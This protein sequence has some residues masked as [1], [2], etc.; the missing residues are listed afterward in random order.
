M[1]GVERRIPGPPP[2]PLCESFKRTAS[3]DDQEDG[4]RETFTLENL[5]D[6]EEEGKIGCCN[7]DR[8][9]AGPPAQKI[10]GGQ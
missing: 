4:E 2:P 7:R 6:K 9:R 10:K 5:D 8:I 1:N 3:Q